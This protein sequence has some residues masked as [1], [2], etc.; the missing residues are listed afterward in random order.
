MKKF[1]EFVTRFYCSEITLGLFERDCGLKE[2]RDRFIEMRDGWLMVDLK[3]E[4]EDKISI[5]F[6]ILLFQFN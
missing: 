5:S 2:R 3:R 1:S 6:F 4:N